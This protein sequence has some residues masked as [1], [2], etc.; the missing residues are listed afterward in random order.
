MV[1]RALA[2][3]ACGER[4]VGYGDRFIDAEHGPALEVMRDQARSADNRMNPGKMVEI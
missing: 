2:M 4:G 1:V 3:E